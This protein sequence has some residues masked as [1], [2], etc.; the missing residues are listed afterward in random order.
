VDRFTLPAGMQ[1]VEARAE[2]VA[3]FDFDR[4]IAAHRDWK[5]KLREAIAQKE[6]LDADS[7]CRDDRCPLGQWLHG[8]G[9]AQWGSRPTFVALLE[10]HAAFHVAA[11]DVARRI[12]AGSYADAERLIGSG[13][14]FASTST[15]VATLLTRAKRGL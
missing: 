4:A 7:I 1:A 14:P 6:Q 5:V 8:P 15:E 3:D 11:G 12:N 2:A 10:R 13:S 9:G